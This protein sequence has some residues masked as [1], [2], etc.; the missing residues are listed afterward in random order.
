M[1]DVFDRVQQSRTGLEKLLDFIPGWKGYQE[2]QNRREADKILRMA[3]AQKLAVQ[4]GRLE[5]AQVDLITAGRIDLVDDLGQAVTPLQ[6]FIDR[7]RFATYGYSSVFDA[8][9]MKQEQ[10]AQL[11]DFDLQM[12]GYVDRLSEANDRLL[13]AIGSG[14]GIAETIRIIR[15]IVREANE[16]Y[17]QRT[18]LI[19]GNP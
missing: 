9:K 12:F 13:E 16:T 14:E 11:Y 19:A 6:T 10:L 7:V 5:A 17:G 15:G 18:Q 4:R 1:A 8:L 3:L 2:Q